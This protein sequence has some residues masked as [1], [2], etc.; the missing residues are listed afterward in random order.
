MSPPRRE[1]W[2]AQR[3][4]SVCVLTPSPLLSGRRADD[5]SVLVLPS[6]AH[7]GRAEPRDAF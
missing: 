5:E 4:G 3:T 7:T 2:S 6:R 1:H